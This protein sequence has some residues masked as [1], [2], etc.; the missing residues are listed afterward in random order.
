[1]KIYDLTEWTRGRIV[2]REV[3]PDRAHP[4][5]VWCSTSKFF[6]YALQRSQYALTEEE[7]RDTISMRCCQKVNSLKKQQV[8]YLGL[9]EKGVEVVEAKEP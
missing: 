3:T 7:A 6:P 1:M 9:L 4:G 8:R 2:V 5:V